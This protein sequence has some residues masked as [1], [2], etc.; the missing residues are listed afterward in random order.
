[1]TLTLKVTTRSAGAKHSDNRSL[2]GDFA[3][4]EFH[5]HALALFPDPADKWPGIA[6][7]V[8]E[9]DASPRQRYCSC[10]V[11]AKHTCSHV[12]ELNRLARELERRLGEK[13][14][15]ADFRSSIWHR[16]AEILSDGCKE[17]PDTVHIQI[18]K[19]DDKRVVRVCNAASEELLR[20]FSDE[21][22]RRR[23]LERCTRMPKGDGIPARGELLDQLALMTL[24]DTERMM[25]DRGFKTRRQAM[26]ASFWYR[27]AYHGYR[28]FGTEGCAFHPAIEET[29]GAF[30]ITAKNRM[31]E[32]LLR[33]SVPR[34][35]VQRILKTLS[36]NLPN[37]NHLPIHPI[38]L[39]SIFKVNTTTELDLEVRPLIQ[40]I[41]ENGEASF[42]E[43]EDLETYRYGN[44]IYIKEMGILAELE[45][46]GIERRKFGA[47][48]RMVLKKSQVP[49][50]FEVF[51]QDP[52]GSERLVDKE[53]KPLSIIRTFDRIEI[54]PASLER[55]WCWLSVR[56][57]FGN[58]SISL[59]EIVGAKKEGRR[60]IGS[61]GGWIDCESDAFDTLTSVLD[62]LKQ[63]SDN[64]TADEIG[65]SRMDLFRIYAG[66]ASGV[67][68]S[69]EGREKY[70]LERM[71]KLKPGRD[72]PPLGGMTSPLRPYQER[73]V[74]WLL[75]LFENGFGGLLCDDMGLGKTHEV[76]AFMTALLENKQG[77]GPYLVVCP[78]T[79]LSH[80]ERK[81]SM[82]AP[83]LRPV[84]YHGMDRDL[85]GLRGPGFVVITSYGILRRDVERLKDIHFVVAFF[86]EIQS[87]KNPE[88][89][90]YRAA[91]E[92]EAGIKMG[93]T[94]TPIENRLML[95]ARLHSQGRREAY[96]Y[97]LNDVVIT[98]NV[99]DRLLNLSTTADG[100][101]ITTY[102]A[103]G[104][105]FSS[106]TGSTAYNLSAGGPL[107]YPGLATITVT[108]IC[109]FMLGSRPIILPADMKIITRY[110][111]A[112]RGER[113]QV[114]IDGQPLWEM[115]DGDD[116]EIQTAKH[117]LQLLVSSSRDYFTI[118]RNKLHWGSP[119]QPNGLG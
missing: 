107:V 65:L 100:Q 58:Q 113:A 31:Y 32:D 73:G 40:L 116:L 47:P 23:F 42:F 45:P 12:K 101:L 57:G 18:L 56:Y 1:M 114:I 111:A 21:S 19:G 62:R 108:P 20:H 96:R 17:T 86:D 26:E 36:E 46:E 22:V 78:T 90:A 88:T 69:G 38:P 7:V 81:I 33:M 71:L 10:S 8:P 50:F 94:G 2:D 109:P 27:V 52:P 106:P 61:E 43:R 117:F 99:L 54:T 97:A 118:L 98:K 64:G 59:G 13:S 70:L 15:E 72:L 77:E 35:R 104:L 55:D 48:V 51:A 79:V 84:V 93:L 5:R 85:D 105:I 39:K 34:D 25:H 24:T 37:Q 49:S 44:L 102:R 115:D 67:T 28:E 6:I 29:S 53:L 68:I 82:H 11:Y 16:L 63:K 119:T 91:R 4:M 74:E 75:F 9:T 87:I 103:D 60:Y 89:V 92:I 80:W 41:Q 112:N 3:R 76:M 110:Q 66:A 30:T 95:R 83:L 14:L